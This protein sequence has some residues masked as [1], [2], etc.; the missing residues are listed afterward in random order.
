[1]N[2]S[3]I[4]SFAESVYK[5]LIDP[6]TVFGVPMIPFLIGSVIAFEFGALG[7]LI[8]GPGVTVGV[9]I[10]YSYALSW[11]RQVGA[12]DIQRLRQT[13]LRA[14]IRWGQR[15]SRERWGAVSYGPSSTRGAR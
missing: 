10:I 8:G 11:A 4:T 6:T 9:I 12:S 14:M 15:S 5:G 3:D 13:Y 2:D 1:M 7:F